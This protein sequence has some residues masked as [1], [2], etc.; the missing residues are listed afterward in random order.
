[1]KLSCGWL[2][3]RVNTQLVCKYIKD[4]GRTACFPLVS[5]LKKLLK[6]LSFMEYRQTYRDREREWKGGINIVLSY[7]TSLCRNR[8]Y[9]TRKRLQNE[10]KTTKLE[11]LLS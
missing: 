9:G 4:N 7:E 2:K 11:P 3:T 5:P 6:F 10:L 1:V 8:F